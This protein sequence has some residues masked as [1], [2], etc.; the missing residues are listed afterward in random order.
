MRIC[1]GELSTSAYIAMNLSYVR[2][3]RNLNIS[4]ATVYRPCKET[5]SVANHYKTERKELRS[6]DDYIELSIIGLVMSRPS[7][8]VP[9]NT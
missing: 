4:L 5:G 9:G 6:L 7:V 1:D 2:I 3:A 8:D